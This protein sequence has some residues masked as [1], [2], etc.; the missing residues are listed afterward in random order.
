MIMLRKTK[1][2]FLYRLLSGKED[3]DNQC[4]YKKMNDLIEHDLEQFEFYDE[5]VE[6]E[7]E[8]T[9][10]PLLYKV[11]VKGK[12]TPTWRVYFL[13]EN[14]PVVVYPLNHAGIIMINEL[15]GGCR[16][17]KNGMEPSERSRFYIKYDSMAYISYLSSK[18]KQRYDEYITDWITKHLEDGYSDGNCSKEYIA[19]LK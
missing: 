1:P 6:T 7:N 15:Y 19:K 2:S 16:L 9:D 8:Y 4:Y 10:A 14:F 5:L 18:W 13:G 17:H 12:H 11:V 3:Y